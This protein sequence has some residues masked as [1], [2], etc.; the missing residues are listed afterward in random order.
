MM[1]ATSTAS[2]QTL[3]VS[4]RPWSKMTSAQKVKVLRLQIHKDRSVIRFWRNHQDPTMLDVATKQTHWAKTSLR[5]STHNLHKYVVASRVGGWPPHHNL[6]MC[7]Y[8]HEAST[9]PLGWHNRDS[10]HNGHYGGMQMHYNWGYG[11]VGY[12]YNYSQLEQEW[13]AERG[14]KANGYSHTWLTGQWAHYDCLA[15][16]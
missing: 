12:A 1:G 10:G 15:Y 11:I 5:I 2:A 3:Q 7:E 14:Y 9:A 16:A 13:A 8:R 6:W 4:H